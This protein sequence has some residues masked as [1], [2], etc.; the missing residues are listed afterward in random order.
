MANQSG[1]FRVVVG[2]VDFPTY[3]SLMPG[4]RRHALLRNVVMQFSPAHT[5]PELEILLD[6]ENAPRFRIGVD[7]GARLG[8]TTNLPLRGQKAMR[9]SV[10]LSENPD[11][12]TARVYSGEP[13]AERV[14]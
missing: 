9:G 5:E 3:E 1:R 4:G 10:V 13:E 2:P 8:V 11:E 7:P 6:T 14:T 12:A